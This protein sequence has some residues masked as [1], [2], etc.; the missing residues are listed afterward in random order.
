VNRARH[1][2]ALV[3]VL[4]A[5]ACNERLQLTNIQVGRAI[6]P[7]GSV[8]MPSTLFKHN[9]TIYVAVLTSGDSGTVGV[10]WM[11]GSQVIDE[12]TKKVSFKGGGATEFHL[13]NAG[14]FPEGDYSVEVFVDG[15]SAGKRAFKVGDR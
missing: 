14:G 3:V 12:P 6:N 15:V 2:A 4:L 13:Q 10:K 1:A 9:E 8:S 7:D 11:Y 5:A